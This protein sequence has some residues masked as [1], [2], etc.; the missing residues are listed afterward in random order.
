MCS[1]QLR[2]EEKQRTVRKQRELEAE[3]AQQEG[4]PYIPYSATWYSQVN[5]F[6]KGIVPFFIIG[7]E[8]TNNTYSMVY[9]LFFKIFE[10]FLNKIQISIS[11]DL[12]M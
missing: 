4:R 11:F 9:I 3:L 7:V 12:K 2:L 6:F 5:L 10:K 1:I 8:F